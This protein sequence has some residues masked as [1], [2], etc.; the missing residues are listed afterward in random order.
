MFTLLGRNIK[1]AYV[2]GL[3]S[4]PAI[5]MMTNRPLPCAPLTEF[6]ERGPGATFKSRSCR[7]RGRG[8]NP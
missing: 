8:S 7:R 6:Q 5:S 1:P 3:T 4:G 2:L